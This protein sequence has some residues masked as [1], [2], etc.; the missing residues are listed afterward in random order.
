M[1]PLVAL[2]QCPPVGAALEGVWLPSTC[3]A[4]PA[5]GSTWWLWQEAGEELLGAQLNMG[6]MLVPSME[7][8]PVVQEQDQ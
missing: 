7:Q 4:G 1:A 2:A 3:T 6:A 5:L 8:A